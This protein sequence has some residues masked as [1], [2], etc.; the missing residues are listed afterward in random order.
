MNNETRNALYQN[1]VLNDDTRGKGCGAV[2]KYL[3]KLK[4]ITMDLRGDIKDKCADEKGVEDLMNLKVVSFR[5]LHSK[6]GVSNTFSLLR[7]VS[8]IAPKEISKWPNGF[9][10]SYG[11][12]HLM[13]EKEPPPDGVEL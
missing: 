13:S 1:E 12:F 7:T 11:A 3:D 4:D 8:K 2:S 9:V 5:K 10:H 6:D